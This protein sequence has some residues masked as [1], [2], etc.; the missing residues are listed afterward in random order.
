MSN[1]TEDSG[2]EAIVGPADARSQ[3]TPFPSGCGTP[4]SG[5]P[6]LRNGPKEGL[7]DGDAPQSAA[8]SVG[9]RDERA[10]QAGVEA[11]DNFPQA[12]LRA[13]RHR[14][15]ALEH[16]RRRGFGD[17]ADDAVMNALLALTTMALDPGAHPPPKIR[18]WLLYR[19]ALEGYAL[20]RRAA[21]VAGTNPHLGVPLALAAGLTCGAVAH[22][23]LV[24][25]DA[26]DPE[27]NLRATIEA[28]AGEHWRA[29]VGAAVGTLSSQ[30][31]TTLHA[32]IERV[33][34][35]AVATAAHRKRLERARIRA[36][37]ALA[38][39]GVTDATIPD[40]L[41]PHAMRPPTAG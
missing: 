12:L 41:P 25:A 23:G 17:I 6:R 10:P 30:D 14:V 24:D 37:R 3:S 36:R 8:A 7:R 26:G 2:R 4:C 39:Y 40:E 29:C 19:S 34:T 33:G 31:L 9:A 11:G 27:R 35:G 20:R 21:A 32:E 5:R 1:H 38:L 18:E 28:R 16:L 15:H 22:T 13:A